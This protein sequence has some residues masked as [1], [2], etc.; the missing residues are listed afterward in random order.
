MSDVI[1]YAFINYIRSCIIT[2]DITNFKSNS[3]VT[4]ILEHVTYELGL[5]YYEL[6][7]KYTLLTP[8]QITAYCNKNDLYGE[9][10]KCDY[11]WIITSPSNFRYLFHSHLILSHMKQKGQNEYCVAEIGCGYGGLCLALTELAPLYNITLTEYHLID[12]PDIS[13][14]QELYLSNFSISTNL[15]FHSAYTYGSNITSSNLFLISNYCFSE[16]DNEHQTN[17]IQKLFPKVLYGFMTWN[18]ILL[19]D[20]GFNMIV[21]DEYPLTSNFENPLLNN[22]YIYF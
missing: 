20:F 3:N 19:Y 17:Y 6:I 18:H 9:G 4:D 13:S 8:E 16:I 7:Q 11:G 12:L 15:S 14:L 5:E 21:Q 22:K 2:G 1:Y 10:Y